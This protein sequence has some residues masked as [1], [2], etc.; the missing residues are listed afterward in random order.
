[1]N[2]KYNRKGLKKSITIFIFSI[3]IL[4]I[5]YSRIEYLELKTVLEK[6]NL[7]L[8][9]L[10]F[11]INIL[12]GIISGFRY[13]YFSNLF[14]IYPFP[15]VITSIKS[16]FIAGSFNVILPSKLADLGK[17]FICNKI[18][19]IN[20]TYK[21]YVFTL[22]EKITDL[23]SLF[24]LT[25]VAYSI[26]IYFSSFN[27]NTFGLKFLERI[28]NIQFHYTIIFLLFSF[29]ILFN[30][31]I[32]SKILKKYY[33]RIP[34]YLS[35]IFLFSSN[36]PPAKLIQFQ[37]SSILFWLLNLFQILIFAFALNIDLF[38]NVG[39]LVIAL[40]VI[41]GLVPISLAGIG[42]REIT[43]IFFLEPFFGSVKPLLLGFLF[44]SRYIIP[45]L[46]GIIFLNDISF[47]RKIIK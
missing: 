31:Y 4:I 16:Y 42:S 23:I 36:I 6:S 24:F 30:P 46:I 40:T 15:K 5:L 27:F 11:L 38:S 19:G 1:M 45:A 32:Y 26:E 37:L 41:S 47:N 14:N 39:I 43:L 29:S 22:Y 7:I 10:G 3:S 8:I 33:N 13:S 12:L 34:K 21:L 25:A 17:A 9:F 35:K 20:Y 28:Q 2:L 18:D 44:T